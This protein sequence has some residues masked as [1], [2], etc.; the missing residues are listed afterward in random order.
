[1]FLHGADDYYDSEYWAAYDW[2]SG[3]FRF[4]PLATLRILN[5][6]FAF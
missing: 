5:I 1:M 3:A 6:C 2:N 4:C